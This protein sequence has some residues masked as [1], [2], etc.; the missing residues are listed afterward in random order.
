MA[1]P[2]APR[3]KPGDATGDGNVGKRSGRL[4]PAPVP[5]QVIQGSQPKGSPPPPLS[6]DPRAPLRGDALGTAADD[7]CPF[8]FRR[9][10]GGRSPRTLARVGGDGR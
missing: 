7:G 9:D 3:R 8:G 4:A 5:R 6:E 2:P 10:S 1:L